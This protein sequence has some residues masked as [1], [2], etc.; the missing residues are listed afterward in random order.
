MAKSRETEMIWLYFNQY[1]NGDSDSDSG[2][3]ISCY[4]W[5]EVHGQM[6]WKFPSF[7]KILF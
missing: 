5:L 4:L 1:N 2:Q 6:H 7:H 3:Y